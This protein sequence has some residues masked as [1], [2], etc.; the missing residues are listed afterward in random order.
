MSQRLRLYDLRLDGRLGNAVGICQ[1]D[2]KGYAQFVNAA[3]QRLLYCKEAGEES[4]FGSFAEIQF[5]IS[6]AVPFYTAPREVAR[7]ELVDVCNSPVSVNSQFT[8]YLRFGNGRF[9]K[10]F[11][12]QRCGCF[13]PQVYSRNNV[14]TFTDLTGPPQYIRI[15]PTDPADVNKSVVIQ[16]TDSNNNVVYT[17]NGLNRI[18]GI[19]VLIQQPYSVLTLQGSTVPIPCNSI[20]G[21]QKDAT[22]APVRFTQV[23]PTTGNELLLHT[24]E[25]SETTAWYRRYY[26]N[27]LPINCCF[28]PNTGVT[29]VLVTAIA[30][31]EF[32]PVVSDTDYCLIQNMEAIIAEAQAV[33]FSTIDSAQAKT[34]EQS[35]HVDAV[36][37][38]RGELSHYLGVTAPAT[39]FAPFGSARL[40]RQAIGTLI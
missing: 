36:R 19:N 12:Q 23:D 11:R 25:P 13:H 3:Q 17:Q 35:K 1:S 32:I 14:P 27:Q 10:L 22:V 18:T 38:L 4:W 7:L 16:V 34:N 30:K 9:P 33:R 26:F 20:T 31:L 2:V 28:D 5:Q 29:N 8:E 15:Y 37:Y 40:E 21:I 24:I 39:N 6:R